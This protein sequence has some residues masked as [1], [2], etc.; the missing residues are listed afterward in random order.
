MPARIMPSSAHF[1]SRLATV[2]AILGILLGI[3]SPF[4]STCTGEYN[5]LLEVS[6]EECSV[7]SA[8][9]FQETVEVLLSVFMERT[10]VIV[11]AFYLLIQ[12]YHIV[13]TQRLCQKTRKS[14]YISGLSCFG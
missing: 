13:L 8:F 2:A 1:E 5:V 7:Y 11:V 9:V 4:G 14:Y 12:H 10:L 6:S 3:I